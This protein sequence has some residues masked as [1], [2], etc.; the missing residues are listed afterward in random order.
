MPISLLPDKRVCVRLPAP[1][2]GIVTLLRLDL[3]VC[4]DA[5]RCVAA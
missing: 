2:G 5:A 4:R 3:E 1:A